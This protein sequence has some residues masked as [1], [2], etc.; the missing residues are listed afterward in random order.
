VRLTTSA[1]RTLQSH[2]ERQL[3][4]KLRL[5]GLWKDNGLVFTTVTGT[6]MDGDSLVKRSFKPLMGEHACPRYAFTTYATPSP[7]SCCLEART[8]R[9][10][11]R[12]WGTRI[13]LKRWTRTRTYC[14]ICRKG[15]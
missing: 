15:Q 6:P 3:E 13:F 8:P 2:R 7:P 1:V 12:C 10:Y 9:W 5:A 4:E 11:R 14:R